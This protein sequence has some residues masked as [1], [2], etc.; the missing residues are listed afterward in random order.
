MNKRII[1][2]YHM[3]IQKSKIRQKCLPTVCVLYIKAYQLK[4]Y[5]AP[6]G[7]QNPNYILCE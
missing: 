1:A 5:C 7:N 6:S 3:F 2:K 4:N